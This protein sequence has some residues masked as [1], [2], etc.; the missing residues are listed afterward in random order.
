MQKEQKNALARQL[1]VLHTCFFIV[2]QNHD[3]TSTL[4]HKMKAEIKLLG[5]LILIAGKTHCLSRT[6]PK[7][8]SNGLI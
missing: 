3:I 2:D 6:M 1:L 8:Y 7:K 5:T 4:G